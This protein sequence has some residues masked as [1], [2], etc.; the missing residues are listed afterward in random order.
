MNREAPIDDRRSLHERSANRFLEARTLRRRTM[1]AVRNR[2]KSRKRSARDARLWPVLHGGARRRSVR[3]TA[4]AA[5]GSR[6][7]V[8]QPPLQRHPARRAAHV[9][10]PADQAAAQAR[11]TS[12]TPAS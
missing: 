5:G 3:R 11:G 9:T 1:R 10:D 4:D 7:P 12:S 2:L 6:A 8:R